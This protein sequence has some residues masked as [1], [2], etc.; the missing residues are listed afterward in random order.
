ATPCLDPYTNHGGYNN[1]STCD[2]L[3]EG[4]AVFLPML[5]ARDIEGATAA[6]YDSF[7]LDFDATRM[8]AWGYGLAGESSLT[9]APTR[10][11]LAV[12]ALFWDLF[13]SEPGT[14]NTQVIGQNGLHYPVTYQERFALSIQELWSQLTAARPTTVFEVRQMFG[15]PAITIDLDGD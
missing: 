11:D 14:E 15:S 1:P 2:S 6:I 8:K 4:F 12:G 7:G 10:E 5:A 3:D 13:S 9:F